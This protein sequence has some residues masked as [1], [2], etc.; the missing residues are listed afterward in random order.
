MLEKLNGL[1]KKHIAILFGIIGFVAFFS[2]LASPFQGDDN[3]QIVNNPVAHSLRHVIDLFSGSTFYNGQSLSG[4]FYRPLMSTVYALLYGMFGPHPVMFHILQ[5]ALCIASAFLLCLV[6]RAILPQALAVLIAI[7]FL[8]HPL[9]SQVA[10]AIPSMQDA[11]C[12]FFGILGLWLLATYKQTRVLWAVAGCVLFALLSKEIGAI[13]VLLYILYISLF[14]RKRLTFFAAIVVLPIAIYLALRVH[15]IGLIPPASDIAPIAHAS[16]AERLWILPSLLQF[17]ITKFIAPWH[18]A[19]RYYW[20]HTGFSF[21]DFLIPLAIGLAVIGGFIWSGRYI[22]H[23]RPAKDF[24]WFLFF[25]AWSVIGIVPYLQLLPLDMTACANWFYI[26][27]A[28]ILGMIGLLLKKRLY[29]DFPDYVVTGL[30]II[31]TVLGISTIVQGTYYKSPYRLAVHD[32]S[33]SK[34]DYAAMN[35]I[36]QEM[37]HQNNYDGAISYA[38]QSIEVYPTI[39]N[40]QNLG[41]ALQDSGKPQQAVRAYEKAL[42]YG[43]Q[44]SIYE[45]LAL[46]GLTLDDPKKTEAI[47]NRAVKA[48]PHNFKILVYQALFQDSQ[49]LNDQAKTTITTAAKYGKV[50]PQLNDAIM[51]NKPF[52]LPLPNSSKVIIVQ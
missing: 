42:D 48:E 51:N 2:G 5:A 28:G 33:A 16:L 36:A 6:L 40:Y 47:L 9:N 43:T 18:L 3:F 17:Y 4:S 46:A 34:E 45:N 14:D 39:F 23:H 50:L 37:I 7:V 11:L 19:T 21:K 15:A 31:I 30:V 25:A 49:G 1:T 13:F 27:M 24:A 44:S 32:L 8:V 26:A 52:S 29:D 22:K 12:F 20:V 10:F 35:D 38:K 41:V